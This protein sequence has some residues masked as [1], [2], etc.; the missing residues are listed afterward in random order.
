MNKGNKICLNQIILLNF[1]LNISEPFE[2]NFLIVTD[3]THN[4]IYFVSLVSDETR[5]FDIE[6]GGN[7]NAVVYNPVEKTVIWADTKDKMIHSAFLNGSNHRIII[8]EGKNILHL[9]HCIPI[10]SLNIFY[11]QNIYSNGVGSQVLTTLVS[12][13]PLHSIYT[14]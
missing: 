6:S 12:T 13:L 4:K 3:W 5:A 1:V 7:P 14:Q 11:C 10:D 2:D 9:T 8:N